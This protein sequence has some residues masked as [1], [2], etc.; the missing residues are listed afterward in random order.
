VLSCLHVE[1]PASGSEEGSS[2]EM[3]NTERFFILFLYLFTV[4]RRALIKYGVSVGQKMS[5]KK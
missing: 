3:R 4:G 5:Y 2:Q 1:E